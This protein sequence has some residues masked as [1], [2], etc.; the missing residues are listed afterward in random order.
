MAHEFAVAQHPANPVFAQ[1]L[2]ADPEQG[3]A[4]SRVGIAAAVVEQFSVEGYVK[5]ALAHGHEQDIDP[6]LAEIPLRA[7]QAQ[8]Q[9]ALGRQQAQH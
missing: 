1:H 3:D 8:A 6:A 4:V 9:L 2:D 7:V 5:R